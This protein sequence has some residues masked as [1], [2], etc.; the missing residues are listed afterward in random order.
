MARGKGF[1]L[2]SATPLTRSSYHAG[3]DFERLKTARQAALARRGLR[4]HVDR[5][6]MPTHAEQRRSPSARATVRPGRRCRALPG[7]PALVR[8][9]PRP[10]PRGR[11]SGRRPHHRLQDVPRALHQ[12]RE[13]DRAEHRIDV[14]Y[15]EGP[16]RYLN[17]HWVFEPRR[18]AAAASTST[19]ISS[20]AR[21]CCR[22]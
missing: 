11:T 8:G 20:S 17:N 19:S 10:P 2:V 13:L 16:F 6:P 1:L 22:R 14:A 5:A 9:G 12:P 3:D 4:R 21:R 15:T 7:V 18:T